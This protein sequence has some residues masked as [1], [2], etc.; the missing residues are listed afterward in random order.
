[1]FSNRVHNNSSWS[2]NFVDY[3]ANRKRVWDFLLIVSSDLGPCRVSELLELLHT[4]SHF[5]DISPLFGPKFKDV[6]IRLYPWRWGLRRANTLRNLTVKIFWKN[7]NLCDHNPPTLQTD[8]QADRQTTYHRNTALCVASRCKNEKKIQNLVQSSVCAV[9]DRKLSCIRC[10]KI[11]I[12]W[13]RKLK[14]KHP[15]DAY[16]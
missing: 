12:L 9:C 4:E 3:G 6:P 1:M 8:G 2:S 13:Y 7:P 14:E 5:F 15:A 11:E 16:A 10:T